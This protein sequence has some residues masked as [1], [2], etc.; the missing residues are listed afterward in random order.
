[1]PPSTQIPD[2]GVGATLIARGVLIVTH[3]FRWCSD[4][5]AASASAYPSVALSCQRGSAGRV[6]L[7]TRLRT[8]RRHGG[9]RVPNQGTR[10]ANE[11]LRVTPR[12]GAPR[13]YSL[14]R[15]AATLYLSGLPEVP[16]TT[17]NVKVQ[18]RVV[19]RCCSHAYGTTVEV[20]S[21]RACQ[22]PEPPASSALPV[23]CREPR[24]LP[25]I[26]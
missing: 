17:A 14:H 25:R 23:P 2:G 9:A 20:R 4:W 19:Q 15:V 16:P 11:A 10:F 21:R 8:D 13:P 6:G 24:T 26:G 1:M 22:R 18:I 5:R 7:V 3:R 12:T